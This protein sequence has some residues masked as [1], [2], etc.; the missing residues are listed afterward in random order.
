[1]FPTIVL[2]CSFTFLKRMDNSL[3]L[4]IPQVLCFV[5]DVLFN[6]WVL[7]LW[8]LLYG[9]PPRAQISLAKVVSYAGVDHHG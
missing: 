1:M 6:Q 3:F 8:Q 4:D 5:P 2:S 7:L 9:P